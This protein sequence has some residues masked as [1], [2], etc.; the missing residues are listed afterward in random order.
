M[1]TVNYVREIMVYSTMASKGNLWNTH[2]RNWSNHNGSVQ[3]GVYTHVLAWLDSVWLSMS[4]QRYL[5][6]GV[7]NWWRACLES[8]WK[9]FVLKKLKLFSWVFF[10][11]KSQPF[12]SF[13]K[14]FIMKQT[15]NEVVGDGGRFQQGEDFRRPLFE[16]W[17]DLALPKVPTEKAPV[18]TRRRTTSNIKKLTHWQ[19]HCGAQR[20]DSSD[21]RLPFLSSFSPLPGFT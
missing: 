13:K 6:K 1:V 19:T 17:F 21:T 15:H 5:F 11:S 8:W 2:W 14:A 20:K 16:T 12:F 7:C 4:A 9:D 3:W 10:P 18:C